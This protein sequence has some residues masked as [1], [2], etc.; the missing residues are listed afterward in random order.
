MFVSIST[1]RAYTM[2]F[3]QECST[4]NSVNVFIFPFECPGNRL[5]SGSGE[6]VVR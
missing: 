3:F 6:R 1:V 5:L 2:N 4:L